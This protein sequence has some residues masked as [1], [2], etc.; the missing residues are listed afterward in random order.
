V[1]L[2]MDKMQAKGSLPQLPKEG[3]KPVITTG[4]D[5]LGRGND[6]QKLMLMVQALEPVKDMAFPFIN[7][8]AF[9]SRV[10]SS[11]GI[12]LEGLI[13]TPEDMNAEAQAAQQSQMMADSMPG[14]AQE[15]MKG[16]I[17]NSGG[18]EGPTGGAEAYED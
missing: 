11:L 5:A 10:G 3:I 13:K 15:A 7:M 8:S 6:L 4:I 18:Q 17:Q 1:V 2:F 12:E 9:I 16:A 14:V